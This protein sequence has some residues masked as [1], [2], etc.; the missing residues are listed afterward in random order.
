M[1]QGNNGFILGVVAVVIA[2]YYMIVTHENEI[3]RMEEIIRS[4]DETLQLQNQA[5]QA[6]KIQNQY[7]LQYYYNSQ[8]PI[9]RNVYTYD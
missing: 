5:I 6:Q 7:L 9:Q 8:S 1:N 3:E 4:Q 2:F